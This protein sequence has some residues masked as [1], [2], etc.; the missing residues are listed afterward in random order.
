MEGIVFL[1]MIIFVMSLPSLFLTNIN[2]WRNLPVR[3]LLYF[4]GSVV[5]IITALC[6]K[7]QPADK[8]VY[9]ATGFIFIIVHA[10]FY[11]KTVKQKI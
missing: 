11:Y 5:F 10:V 9:L 4:S 6:M 2:Y 7:L 1:N 3:L 8:L